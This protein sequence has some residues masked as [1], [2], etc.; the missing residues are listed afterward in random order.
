[1]PI[2]LRVLQELRLSLE[3]PDWNLC[4]QHGGNTR[5]HHSDSDAQYQS[6]ID[7]MKPLQRELQMEIVYQPHV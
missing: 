4:E 3:I 5:L 1:M 6:M 7:N 2:I